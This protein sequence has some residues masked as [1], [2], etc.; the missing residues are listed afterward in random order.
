MTS[1]TPTQTPTE[2]R[3]Q[4]LNRSITA[5]KTGI[6]RFLYNMEHKN[7][8]VE[9]VDEL[10]QEQTYV[11]KRAIET[12]VEI[13]EEL[14]TNPNVIGLRHQILFMVD[15]MNHAHQTLT[16]MKVYLEKL[17]TEI[18]TETKSDPLE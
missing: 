17:P 2:T 16:S 10:F 6:L 7:K 14:E 1:T 5:I 4:Y 9:L 3:E 13:E 8:S 18:V 11:L 12:Q 15:M